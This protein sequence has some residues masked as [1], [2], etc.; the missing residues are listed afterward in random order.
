MGRHLRGDIC[1]ISG[2]GQL[3]TFS[4]VDPAIPAD[5]SHSVMWVR[6]SAS[7]D[8][9][10]EPHQHG[11]HRRRPHFPVRDHHRHL[12]NAAASR[13]ARRKRPRTLDPSH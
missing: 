4:D 8:T 12:R 3:L 2:D 10:T 1:D 6:V 13:P 5:G 7:D 11:V 9:P